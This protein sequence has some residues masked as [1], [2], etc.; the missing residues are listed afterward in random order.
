M[1]GGVKTM[2]LLRCLRDLTCKRMWG[3]NCR[4]VFTQKI[5]QMFVLSDIVIHSERTPIQVMHVVD[6]S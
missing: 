1:I 3:S 5:E 6:N 2:Q 4:R